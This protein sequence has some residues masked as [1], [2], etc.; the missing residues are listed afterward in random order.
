MYKSGCCWPDEIIQLR[1]LAPSAWKCIFS[2]IQEIMTDRLTYQ[3]TEQ[4]TD[5]LGQREVTLPLTYG[6]SEDVNVKIF[7]FDCCLYLIKNQM[8]F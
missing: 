5:R 3:P 2:P 7:A 4:H 1:E 6:V 8:H